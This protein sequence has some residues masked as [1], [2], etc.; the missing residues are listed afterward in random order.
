MSLGLHAD[1][2][3]AAGFA[4]GTNQSVGAFGLN[5]RQLWQTRDQAQ[6]VHLEQ[7]LAESGTISEI[8]A[9][10]DDV[11]GRL[12]VELFEQ[13]E[14]KSLLAFQAKRVNRIQLIDRRMENKLLQQAQA[15]VKIGTQLAGDGA[16]V[17]RLR[18]LA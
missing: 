18:Q 17:E 5:D 13:F 4:Q 16:V 11:I 7:G 12:P 1:Q 9:R 3:F 14:G 6:V 15:A 8:A 2:A 10:N